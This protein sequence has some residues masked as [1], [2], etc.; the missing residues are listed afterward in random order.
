M[1]DSMLKSK[2]QQCTACCLVVRLGL[3]VDFVLTWTSW[4]SYSCCE[5]VHKLC[6]SLSIVS[7]F[8]AHIKL[9]L[10]WECAQTLIQGSQCG[11]NWH[12]Q[13]AAA[14]VETEIMLQGW[15]HEVVANEFD[16]NNEV[17]AG[18]RWHCLTCSRR[19]CIP[20][21]ATPLASAPPFSYFIKDDAV[22]TP[23]EDGGYPNK[24]LR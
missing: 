17:A 4:W 6:F 14:T 8:C 24:R 21:V 3:T 5:V 20:S 22:Q 2:S 10:L 18:S 13:N 9:R 7:Q 15:V 1:V 16:R 12:P 11:L 19:C 23:G